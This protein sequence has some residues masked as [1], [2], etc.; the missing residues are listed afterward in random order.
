VEDSRWKRKR[1]PIQS[2]SPGKKR[3]YVIFYVLCYMLYYSYFYDF[4]A[5]VFVMF[6]A[7]CLI[8]LFQ[9][10]VFTYNSSAL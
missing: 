1:F 8:K 7:Q 3:F 2:R 10:N 9:Q 6:I 4:V 5:T